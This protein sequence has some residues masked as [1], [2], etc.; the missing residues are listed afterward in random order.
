MNDLLKIK[1]HGDSDGFGNIYGD[2]DG[3]GYGNGYGC[4]EDI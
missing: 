3:N 4:E 1:H 2:G